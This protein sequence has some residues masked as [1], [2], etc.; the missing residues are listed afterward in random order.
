MRIVCE[1]ERVSV[2]VY[3]C[4]VNECVCMCVSVSVTIVPDAVVVRSLEMRM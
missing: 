2:C 4:R 3:V 1:W